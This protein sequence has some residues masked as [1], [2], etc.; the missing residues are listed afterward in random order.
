MSL[1]HWTISND[2]PMTQ[3]FCVVIEKRLKGK[4]LTHCVR[5]CVIFI[6]ALMTQYASFPS[7]AL[8][9]HDGTNPPVRAGGC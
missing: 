6:D 8:Q 9:A 4:T 3:R 2:A 1:R 5:H 7:G